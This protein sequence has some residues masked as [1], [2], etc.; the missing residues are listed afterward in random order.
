MVAYEVWAIDSKSEVRS[1]LWGCFGGSVRSLR[2]RLRTSIKHLVG[3]GLWGHYSLQNSLGGQIWPQIWNLWPKLHML[4]CLFGQFRPVL[5]LLLNFDRRKMK[6]HNSP[7]LEL[8]ASSQL[9]I[10][11]S[12]M[13][14]WGISSILIPSWFQGLLRLRLSINCLISFSSVSRRPKEGSSWGRIYHV[15]LEANTLAAIKERK[16]WHRAK[17]FGSSSKAVSC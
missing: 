17:S 8:S 3:I 5:A 9:R 1:D 14:Y 6:E 15:V 4:P 13:Y 7:L 11:H 16:E 2:R 12:C 10:T